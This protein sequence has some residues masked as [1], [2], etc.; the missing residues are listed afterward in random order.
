VLPPAPAAPDHSGLAPVRGV[1][2]SRTA[3][4]IR[5]TYSSVTLGA[6]RETNKCPRMD[7]LPESALPPIAAELLQSSE[8][9][10]CANSEPL[11]QLLRPRMSRTTKPRFTRLH[12]GQMG[13]LWQTTPPAR[14]VRATALARV[15]SR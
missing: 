4:T 10:R 11:H 7:G 5:V 2:L 9:T 15:P 12:A 14:L 1:R 6:G 3:R 8:T 13:A